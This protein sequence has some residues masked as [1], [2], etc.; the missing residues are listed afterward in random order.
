MFMR[1]TICLIMLVAGLADCSET[2]SLDN[3]EL[4]AS[5]AVQQRG[6]DHYVISEA[7]IHLFDRSGAELGLVRV[8]APEDY[9]RLVTLT[10]QDGTGE[11]MK[12]SRPLNARFNL[13]L[14]DDTLSSALLL[15]PALASLFDSFAIN[16]TLRNATAA[17]TSGSILMSAVA[18]CIPGSAGSPDFCHQSS[19][20]PC[21]TTY[22]Y[23]VYADRTTAEFT[24]N[25]ECPWC[26][27][28]YDYFWKN[29]DSGPGYYC[30]CGT[31]Y[32]EKIWPMSCAKHLCG[33]PGQ[34]DER[35][36]ILTCM[37]PGSCVQQSS[38]VGCATW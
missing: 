6:I 15:D 25:W 30:L 24:E 16:A 2:A 8:T 12:I 10:L 18:T 5:P 14:T 1:Q 31:R 3:A 22:D 34:R 9:S 37:D 13:G 19:S 23:T 17:R 38:Y 33:V 29:G 21:T 36:S 4:S 11:E 20:H 28:V 32:T 35:N 7:E 26:E 27:G